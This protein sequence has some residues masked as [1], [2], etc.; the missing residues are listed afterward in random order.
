M[1]GIPKG[2]QP[3]KL[4]GI[5]RRQTQ[6]SNLPQSKRKCLFWTG[7]E[8]DVHW[9]PLRTLNWS[10]RFGETCEM[11]LPANFIKHLLECIF[12]LKIYNS[13]QTTE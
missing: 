1:T 8:S 9:L 2:A 5:K 6:K 7:C 10:K 13:T 4:R 12:N 11:G 3:I